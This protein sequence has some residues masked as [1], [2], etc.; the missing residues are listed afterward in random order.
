MF[1]PKKNITTVYRVFAKRNGTPTIKMLIIT[2]VEK[3]RQTFLADILYTIRVSRILFVE[4]T[5]CFHL[6]SVSLEFCS[7]N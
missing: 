6:Q 4:L 2:F 3:N 1:L 7:W 5:V